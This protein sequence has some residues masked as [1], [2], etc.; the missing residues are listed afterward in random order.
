MSGEAAADKVVEETIGSRFEALME[1]YPAWATALGIHAHDGRLADLSRSAKEADIVAERRFVAELEAIDR[2]TLSE[3][4]CFERELALHGARLRLFDAE[5]VRG[6]ERSTS[7]TDEIGTALFLLAA[8][9]FAPL[10]ERLLSLTHRIEGI[11]TALEQVR[12]RLAD[13][14]VRLWLEKEEI[15]GS[16][17]APAGARDRHQRH[18]GVAGGQPGAGAVAWRRTCHQGG[19][20][21]L[22]RLDRDTA[23]PQCRCRGSGC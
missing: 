11:P 7:A 19:A 23:G 14:P 6:W 16:R 1:T 20:P 22:C 21:R 12:D 10:E 13:R 4:V 3:A 2:A 15:G 9:E 18:R 8:R 17:V 5:V